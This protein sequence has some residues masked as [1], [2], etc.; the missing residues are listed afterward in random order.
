MPGTSKGQL[1]GARAA[2]RSPAV[3]T[4]DRRSSADDVRLPHTSRA[5]PGTDAS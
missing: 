4:V 5:A 2:R 1:A 3:V